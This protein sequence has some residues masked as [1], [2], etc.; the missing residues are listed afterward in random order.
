MINRIYLK[1]LYLI[2]SMLGVLFY[3]F[4]RIGVLKKIPFKIIKRISGTEKVDLQLPVN[5]DKKDKEHFSHNTG[6]N[7]YDLEVH[8]LSNVNVS[9]EGI[10]FKG[11]NN[12]PSS[13]PNIGFRAQYAWLFITGQYWFKKKQIGQHNRTYV[14]LFDF[15]STNN[16]YHWLI[17]ALPRFLMIKEEMKQEN[18]S[19]LLPDTC[20]KFILAIM[21]HFELNDITFIN[22]G[23][24]FFAPDLLL[25][26]YTVGSGHIHPSYVRDVQAHLLSRINSNITNSRVYVSRGK[27]KARKIHNENE[28]L[29]VLIPLGFR[30]VY[31]EE[32]NFEEQVRIVRNTDVLVTSHGANV[33]NCMFMPD[34]SKVLEIIRSDQPNFCYWALATVTNK[35]YY[36]HFTKVVGNDHL[37]VDIEQFKIHLHKVLN[38]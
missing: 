13:F 34:N 35:K 15:W 9:T 37:L 17:D 4:E 19:L 18:V 1:G 38:D 28:L 5:F 16:Y 24:Y 32:L 7:T 12:L 31:F 11:M 23:S 14:L 26:S 20:G 3:L 22:R 2:N 27:Q 8:R 21:K 36:Y 6:Y 30:V 33:T 29:N 10:V 25:P